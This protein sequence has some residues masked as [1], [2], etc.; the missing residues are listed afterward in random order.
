MM[1]ENFKV[2]DWSLKKCHSRVFEGLVFSSSYNLSALKLM[3]LG[4]WIIKLIDIS[5]YIFGYRE[6]NV[7]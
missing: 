3:S 5:L 1:D 7:F 2:E 6:L 4:R